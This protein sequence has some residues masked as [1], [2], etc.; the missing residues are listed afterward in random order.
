MLIGCNYYIEWISVEDR[1]CAQEK[2]FKAKN[3]LIQCSATG[4]DGEETV[5]EWAL[6]IGQ[7]VYY[8]V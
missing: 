5:G 8:I 7:P 4:D 3:K 2:T 1:V 6:P